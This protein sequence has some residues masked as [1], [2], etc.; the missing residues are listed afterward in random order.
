[1]TQTRSGLLGLLVAGAV[2]FLATGASAYTAVSP[3]V[4]LRVMSFNIFY[5]GDELNM[6]TGQFCHDPAGCPKTLDQ[7]AY[8][9]RAS[10]ARFSTTATARSRPR[11]SSR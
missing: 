1:V 5:G 6:G 7:T 4:T 2:L 8:A 3:S 11:R 9:I 10:G